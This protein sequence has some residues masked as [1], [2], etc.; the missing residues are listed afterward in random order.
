[1]VG[2][3]LSEYGKLMEAEQ[4]RLQSLDEEAKLLGEPAELP[5]K[6]QAGA[7]AQPSKPLDLFLRLPKGISPRAESVNEVLFRFSRPPSYGYGGRYS[8]GGADQPPPFQEVYIGVAAGSKAEDFQGKVL[9]P[10]GATP[11]TPGKKIV[12]PPGRDRME[13]VWIN[14][15][16][17]GNPPSAYQS[18][19][20]T[21]PGVQPVQVAVIFRTP[22]DQAQTPAITKGIDAT[23]QTLAVGPE[24][25]QQRK[26]YVPSKPTK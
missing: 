18:F 16:D 20:I 13:F 15:E 9:Q 10:F 21:I 3:G 23:L 2:C 26:R 4:K 8:S 17:T 7:G 22:K 1:M 6:A 14:F 11:G 25:E 19:F 5:V 12:H 24:A